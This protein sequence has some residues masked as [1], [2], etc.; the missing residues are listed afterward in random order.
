[1]NSLEA[2][3]HQDVATTREMLEAALAGQGFSVL[4]DIQLHEVLKAKLGV[5]HEPHVVLGVCNPKLA[6]QA[7]DV[8]RDIALL[9]PCT[10]ALRQVDDATEVRILDPERAFTLASREAQADLEPVAIDVRKRLQ[11]ALESIRKTT[12]PTSAVR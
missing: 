6:K 7:L 3:I 2:T 5:E 9:L 1:M 12:E 8:D 11:D 10:V 4:A